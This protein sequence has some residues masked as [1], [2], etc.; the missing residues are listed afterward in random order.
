M[1]ILTADGSYTLKSE[2][3]DES[4]HSPSC[5]ALRESM[6]KHVAPAFDAIFANGYKDEICILD[7][8][9]GLGFNSYAS[10]AYAK[11]HFPALRLKIFS[12]EMD[13]ELVVG[14]KTF[15]YPEE[16]YDKNIVDSVC[17]RLYYKDDRYELN[18]AIGDARGLLKGDI[19]RF[20]IVYQDAF[21]PLKNPLLWTYEYFCNIK[22]LLAQKAVVTTYSQASSVKTAM[23]EVGLSV[24]ET[25]GNGVR[26]SVIASNFELCGFKK[27]D[28]ER[29]IQNSPKA[30]SLRDCDF[31]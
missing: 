7:I 22:A 9:F 31:F 4:Y 15:E 14:L 23:H 2:V 30:K 8:C 12:P 20:D 26:G 3:F 11:K 5:G 1:K 13:K 27:V 25:S 10:I 19:G 21:S 18:V 29:K 17:E 28:M 16:I 6:Q 24:Y